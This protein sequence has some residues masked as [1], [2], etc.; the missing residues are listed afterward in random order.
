MRDGETTGAIGI[1]AQTMPAIT[2]R[3][4][5]ATLNKTT[6]SNAQLRLDGS[7]TLPVNLRYLMKKV[8]S[9]SF[10]FFSES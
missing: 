10:L 7:K 3:R 4:L 1:D 6:M 8:G 5:S 9:K 2:V